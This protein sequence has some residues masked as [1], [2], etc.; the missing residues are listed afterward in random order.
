MT[1]R[2]KNRRTV[3]SAAAGAPTTRLCLDLG[4]A[5]G[6]V[7]RKVEFAGVALRDAVGDERDAA[8]VVAT[9]EERYGFVAHLAGRRVGDEAFGAVADLD[10][11]MAAAVGA[12]LLGH[13]ENDDAGVARRIA[14]LALLPDLPLAPD[15]EPDLFDRTALEIRER[16]DDD[17]S[18]RLGLYVGDDAADRRRIGGRDDVRKV[19]DVADGRRDLRPPGA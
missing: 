14:G 12:R 10:A 18:A 7:E 3:E 19:V 11:N 15:V 2:R 9:L 5:K 13:D 8:A 17:L 1:K 16:D 4:R 6:G